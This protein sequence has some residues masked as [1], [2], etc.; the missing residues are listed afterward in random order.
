MERYFSWY[1]L[2]IVFNS[3]PP[4][5]AWKSNASVFTKSVCR[6]GN[7]PIMNIILRIVPAA[8]LCLV[9]AI[10]LVYNIFFSVNFPFQDDFLLIQFI[11]AISGQQIG[12]E[13]LLTEL[14]RTFNDHKA[15][16]PR[17]IALI[18]YT[19]TGHLHFRFYIF[20]VLANI[21]YIFSFVFIQ[22]RK[23]QLPLYYFLPVPFLFF[24]PLFHDI[25]GWALNGMQ[26][27]FLTAFTVTAILIASGRVRGGFYLAMFCCFLATFTHGNG[28]LSFPAIIFY[29][30]CLKDLRKAGLTVV[31]MVICLVIY[32]AGYESGQAVDLPKSIGSFTL[33]FFG[34]IGSGMSMWSYPETLSMLWGL[35]ITAFM[36]YLIVKVLMGYF[37]KDVVIRTGTAE[38]LTLFVFIAVTSF[39]IALFRSWTGSTLASRFQ[40]YAALSTVIFYVFL[41]DYLPFFR[42]KGVLAT[43]LVLSVGYWAYSYY[44][45]TGVVANKKTT[46]LADVY[47]WT[48][49]KNMFSVEKSII[50]NGDFYLSPAYAKGFFRLPAPVV[51]ERQL[52]SMFAATPEGE[53]FKVFLETW[54]VERPLREG[55]EIMEM[56]FLTSHDAPAPRALLSDRF[57]VLR[58]RDDNRI[59][60]MCA[61]PKIEGRKKVFTGRGYFQPGFNTLLRS[62]DLS[63]G[64]YD[65]GVLDVAGHNAPVFHRL[66]RQLQVADGR[67]SLR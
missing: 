29:Y 46:Y 50:R 17:L 19:L 47:N 3:G 55:N 27:T 65:L 26:H 41:V 45:Y 62:D 28:V 49:N 8:V 52:D 34:F 35:V 61:N 54:T 1:Q 40:I 66:D 56:F 22:F 7:H 16:V 10:Y 6:S 20:L 38:L 57:L 36:I 12:V 11:E 14:F 31:F 4:A 48:T 59:H 44:R 37:K 9:V 43:I 33:S 53:D 24:H 15:V 51:A 39:V 60:L 58:S 25:S 63:P 2:T 23:M 5:S 32:L 30:L 21:I 18:D 67:I 42:K 64:G 13:G